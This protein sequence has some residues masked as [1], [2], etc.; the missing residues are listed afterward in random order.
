MKEKFNQQLQDQEPIN[1]EV[2]QVFKPFEGR[3]EFPPIELDDEKVQRLIEAPFQLKG[4][5]G[6]LGISTIPDSRMM[7]NPVTPLGEVQFVRSF[8]NGNITI[9]K[10][11]LELELDFDITTMG[12]FYILQKYAMEFVLGNET[13]YLECNGIDRERAVKRSIEEEG[14]MELFDPALH[15]KDENGRANVS[16]PYDITKLSQIEARIVAK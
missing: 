13:Y 14:R 3:T 15:L 16:L 5:N 11:P 10:I 4:I 6:R 1:I 2:G 7:L 12:E 9:K 8:E